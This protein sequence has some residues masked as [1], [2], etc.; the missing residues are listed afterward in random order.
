M[1]IGISN[2]AYATS[3]DSQSCI[4]VNNKTKDSDKVL[5]IKSLYKYYVFGGED[6]S[7]LTD[8]YCTA[9]LRKFLSSAY[10]YDCPEGEE[11]YA[12]WLFRSGAQD[13]PSNVCK[14]KNIIKLKNGWYRVNFIDMGVN[15]SVR[16]K[17]IDCG[18]SFKMDEVK[19]DTVL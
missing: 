2:N 19:N 14:I 17:F 4:E 15:G 18:E 9:K 7:P 1:F 10:D 6:F 5:F 12:V 11:C 3:L 13:G 8:L 16:I